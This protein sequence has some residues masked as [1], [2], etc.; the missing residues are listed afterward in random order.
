MAVTHH[1]VKL[2][3]RQPK[4]ACNLAKSIACQTGRSQ[5]RVLEGYGQRGVLFPQSQLFLHW[6]IFGL[7]QGSQAGT[8]SLFKCQSPPLEELFLGEFLRTND[9]R[10]AL[11]LS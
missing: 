6:F 8:L 5:H 4:K 7:S 11:K 9:R 1:I 10:E 3:M 2:P